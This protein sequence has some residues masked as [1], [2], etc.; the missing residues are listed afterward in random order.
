MAAQNNSETQAQTEAMQERLRETGAQLDGLAGVFLRRPDGGLVRQ[1]SP[2]LAEDR[3]ALLAA[4]ADALEEYEEL[5]LRPDSPRY[6][7]PF[8]SAHHPQSVEQPGHD[9]AATVADVFAQCGFQ[10]FF[11]PAV[12]EGGTVEPHWLEQPYADHIGF[13]LAFLSVLFSLAADRRAE[14]GSLMDTARGFYAV[15]MGP[16]LGAY[17]RELARRARTPLY[18]WVAE[19]LALMDT[20]L[21][22]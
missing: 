11:L 22:R 14:A 7:A 17:A 2:E 4:M 20:H 5:F 19:Q 13:E 9:E 8:A 6:L 16:W 12:G 15:H 21:H 18:R 1:V 10:P 3:G